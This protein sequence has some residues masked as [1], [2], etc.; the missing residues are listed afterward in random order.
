[1]STTHG[2]ECSRCEELA[3]RLIAIE[4]RLAVA[5]AKLAASEAENARLREQLAAARKNSSNSSKPPSSDIVKPK[6]PTEEKNEGKRKIGGQP[7][8]RRHTREAWLAADLTLPLVLFLGRRF[9]LDDV[10]RWR[11]GRV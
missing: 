3:A 7:G 11:L 2:G 8:H 9:R 5:E 4:A 6:P 10:R 1:M